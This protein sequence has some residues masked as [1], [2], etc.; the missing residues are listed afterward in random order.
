[1]KEPNP[2]L[3]E[4]L[5]E[6]LKPPGWRE[7][8]GCVVLGAAGA[9]TEVRFAG[10]NLSLCTWRWTCLCALHGLLSG[11]VIHMMGGFRKFPAWSWPLALGWM[12]VELL[13]YR[14]RAS[15]H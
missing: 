1:M 6:G 10:G 12:G 11:G 13:L 4:I 2:D 14:Y 3:I 8:L 9:Y 15:L 7:L 5:F